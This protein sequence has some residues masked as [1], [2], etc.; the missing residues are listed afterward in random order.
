MTDKEIEKALDLCSY[1]I[2]SKCKECP[3]HK[4]KGMD[5]ALGDLQRMALDYINRLKAEKEQIGKE[6]AKK[7]AEILI[8]LIWEEEEGETITIKDLHSAIKDVAMAHYGIEVD[9]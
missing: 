3:A 1:G 6:T 5:C 7:F 2:G 4:Y 9:E 8:S